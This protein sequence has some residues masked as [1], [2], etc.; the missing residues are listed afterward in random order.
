MYSFWQGER[1]RI[2]ASA[3]F[4]GLLAMTVRGAPARAKAPCVIPSA[5]RNPFPPD[6]RRDCLRGGA[7]AERDEMTATRHGP[8]RSFLGFFLLFIE[9]ELFK[10]PDKL[11]AFRRQL[12]L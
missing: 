6:T 5:A 7:N 2:A 1:G 10:D 9:Q 4:V 11:L 12:V 3:S 8:G